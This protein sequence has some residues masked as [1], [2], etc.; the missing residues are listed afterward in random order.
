[1]GAHAPLS[2]PASPTWAGCFCRWLSFQVPVS[3]PPASL[4]PKSGNSLARTSPQHSAIPYGSPT[5]T[6]L[7]INPPLNAAVSELPVS[8]RNV[9]KGLWRQR[10]TKERSLPDWREKGEGDRMWPTKGRS[11]G[12]QTCS[13]TLEYEIRGH[14]PISRTQ[15]CDNYGEVACR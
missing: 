3:T 8:S 13:Q 6:P 11:W 1:M 15:A 12:T 5:P 9:G 4:G 2:Q 14:A 10:Q 7:P